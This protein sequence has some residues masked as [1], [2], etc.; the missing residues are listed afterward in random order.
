ME[1]RRFLAGLSATVP[2]ALAGCM[3][4][5]G[6]EDT[7]STTA[8]TDDT[9]TQTP[10]GTTTTTTDSG[11]LSVGE[12][13]SLGDDR[14]I[15]VVGTDATAFVLTREGT[16]YQ[17][18]AGNTT[19]HVLVTFDVD[20]V[21]DYESLVAENATLT[22]NG[23]ET[24]SDPIFPLGGGA[25]Q[26]TAAYAVP[27]DVTAYTGSV[28][29]D[30]GDTA[31]SWTF[32]SRDIESITQSVDFEVTN[33][34]APDT[35]A[36]E[37]EFGVDIEIDNSGD[38]FEFVTTV[39]GTASAPMRATFDVPASETTTKTLELTAPAADGNSEF[40]V[41]L[42]WGVRGSMHAIPFE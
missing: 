1:R 42:D 41:T 13:T 29:L 5:Q 6:D 4:G 26:F 9:T 24:F 7:T 21:D 34:S 37:A 17:V 18:H 12:K 22:L 14:A 23:E 3:G 31:A 8:P 33:V 19:R 35:V 10:D 25:N 11:P 15:G 32:S 40:R 2:L 39:D 27:N 28:D 20:S 16:D 38:A 36:A 30:T